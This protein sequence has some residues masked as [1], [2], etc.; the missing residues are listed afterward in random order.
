MRRKYSLF[1]LMVCAAAMV[2]ASGAGAAEKGAESPSRGGNAQSQFVDPTDMT[3]VPRLERKVLVRAT[4]KARRGEHAEAVAEIEGHLREHPDQDHFLLRYHLARSHDA[5]EQ[6]EEAR[7][8]YAAAVAAEPRL[9]EAWFGLGHVNYTLR[10][11]AASGDAFLKAFRT[12]IDPQPQT[13]YFA[14]AGY[15]LAE[16]HETAAPLL[17]EL[18]SGRWGTPRHDW[19]AQLASCAISLQRPELAGPVLERYLLEAPG[20]HDAWYLAYQFHVG[21]KDYREAAVALTMVGF[22]RELSPREQR[23]LGDLYTMVDVP[24]LASEK[25]RASLTEEARAEDYERLA[26]ALVAAHDLQGALDS[27][28][29]GLRKQPTP[30]LWSLLGDVHYLRKDYAAAA[31]AFAQ[32]AELDPD[33]GRALLMIGYCHIELGNRGLAIQNLVAAAKHEDQAQLAER[34]L[35]RARKMTDDA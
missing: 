35:M 2:A 22:L 17:E 4:A 31:E 25:Y 21:F 20:S 26:S 34:L 14:S 32:V 15:M 30:R 23:T 5:L 12:A 6:Y 3:Q 19:Y 1:V 10:E 16:D 28:R 18:C 9:S 11:Y 7:E 27:L 13:L 24:A 29:E 8:Q 33:N